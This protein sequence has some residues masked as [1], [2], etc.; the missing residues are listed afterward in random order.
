MTLRG[1]SVF[2]GKPEEVEVS[3]EAIRR[4]TELEPAAREL[5]KGE[6]PLL[7][8][9]FLDMQVNGFRGS[10]YSLEDFGEPHLHGIVAA[11]AEAG[12]TQHV[13]TI[14]SEP[15]ER[16]VRNL[17]A[18]AGLARSSREV[19]QAIAGIH[20][21]GPYISSEDGP[22][23]AHDLRFVREPDFAEFEQWQEAAEG[24]LR[25]VTVAPERRGA[26]PFIERVA[27][28]GVTVAIG[29]T[30][31]APELV[32]EAV[33]A[34]ARLSTHIGN[35]SYTQVPRLRNYIWEQL[36]ADELTAGIIADGFHL[37]P[38]V[39]KVFTRAKG[40]E[41]LVLVSDVALLGGCE[42]GVHKWGNLD[43]EVFPD[44]CRAP[45]SW[46]GRAIC[47]TGTWRTSCSSP[48][49]RWA[50]RC[51]SA[52]S[53]RRACWACPRTTAGWRWGP[54]RTS[55]CFAGNPETRACAWNRPL[56]PARRSTPGGRSPRRSQRR[57]AV[58]PGG[59]VQG[60]DQV[61][62]QGDPACARLL[63]QPQGALPRQS[64]RLVTGPRPAVPQVP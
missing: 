23:G 48:V 13:P 40:L 11:L 26:L 37:P 15:Q 53:T 59:F 7:S 52:R 21:E 44:G 54:R 30:G 42:T 47:W 46:P 22:R 55:C 25:I 64:Y 36:A 4:V 49:C 17:K 58:A 50:R 2:S 45:A 60:G 9:G 38:S 6:L 63:E 12:T 5:E 18:I 34:G 31:A 33:A 32:Q 35:G 62:L 39:V 51:A 61:V 27:A 14:V 43:V 8:P 41:R 24:L 28:A 20:V 29:H 56:A 1:V 16:I 3:G 10:D 19:R 57:Q